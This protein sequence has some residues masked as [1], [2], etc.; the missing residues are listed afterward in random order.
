MILTPFSRI[1]PS[2]SKTSVSDR[3][4]A[5]KRRHLHAVARLEDGL[6]AIQP[7]PVPRGPA[8][9][10]LKDLP[11][12]GQHPALG[13]QVVCVGIAGHRNAGVSVEFSVHLS[14]APASGMAA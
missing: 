7:R 1:H 14:L 12:V 2:S 9:N 6:Q 8:A 3:P 4:Q 11:A 5:S 13:L 10:V